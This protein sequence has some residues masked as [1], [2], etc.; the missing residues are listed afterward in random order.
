MSG[1]YG[2]S[3]VQSEP[4]GGQVIA[5]DS[6]PELSAACQV[7][8]TYERVPRISEPTFLDE[9]LRLALRHEVGLVIPTLDTELAGY[10]SVRDAWAEQGVHVSVS[11]T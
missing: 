5:T 2:L 3:R 11:D 9:T 10:A 8:G 4:L 6:R 1:W 7:A